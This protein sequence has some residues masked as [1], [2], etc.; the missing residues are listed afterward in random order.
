MHHYFRVTELPG[1]GR[2]AYLETVEAIVYSPMPVLFGSLERSTDVGYL[3]F[4]LQNSIVRASDLAV[5]VRDWCWAF[6]VILTFWL[7]GKNVL[8]RD[9]LPQP[10]Q[11]LL[12]MYHGEHL[13]YL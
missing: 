3:L 13:R 8:S 10:W 7:A 6:G 12:P 2:S 9:L 1:E 4:N 5:R 11:L